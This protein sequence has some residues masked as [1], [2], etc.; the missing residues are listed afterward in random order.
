MKQQ[1]N[2]VRQLIL[3]LT[4]SIVG[5]FSLI[6]VYTLFNNIIKKLDQKTTN[7][8]TKIDLGEYIVED[9]Y[10]IR[11]DFYELATTA[12]NKHSRR[13]IEKRINKKLANIKNTLQVLENGGTLKR[14]IRLNI[15][16]HDD[17]TKV[18]TYNKDKLSSVSLEAIDLH[19]KLI[20]FQAM[21]ADLLILLEQKEQYEKNQHIQEYLIYSKRIKRF[22]KSTPAFF[23]RTIEN[24]R[25]LLYE[26]EIKLR[27]LK[28]EIQYEKD[29]YTTLESI[30]VFCII[31]LMLI[32]GYIIAKQITRDNKKLL[33][34]NKELNSN[35][36]ELQSQKAYV[37]G[38]LD[39]Q[40][41][42]IVVSDGEKM[43][44]ANLA[45]VEFFDGYNSFDD[46][47]TKHACICDYFIDMH[48]PEY[49][50]D[51]DYPEGMWFERVLAHPDQLFKAAMKGKDKIHC[52]TLR[53]SQKAISKNESL[54]IITLNDIT[55][56]LFTNK[57]LK[58]LNDNL[59]VLI[60][61][62]TKKLQDLNDNLEQ[63]IKEEVQK[64]REKDKRMIQQ[65]RYAAMGEMIGNIAH[66]W[67]Q[68]LSAILS[69][70]SSMQ[71]QID[72]G[73]SNNK[74]IRKSFV[75]IVKYVEF[76]NQT[77]EDFRAFFKKDKQASDFNLIGILKN[78]LNIVNA[79]YKD[80]RINVIVQ[81]EH[82]TLISNGFPNELA[83]AYINILNNAKDALIEKEI[84]QKYVF[85]KSYQ[86]EEY[87]IV[88]IMDNSGGID[89]T[90]ISKIF[91]PYFTT[92]HQSQ[93]TGI[94]LYM[95][96]YI[97]EKHMK[98]NLSVNNQEFFVDNTSYYGACFKIALPISKNSL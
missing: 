14:V 98:G 35:I 59:E 8:E 94:G 37:R 61:E 72:L 38:L 10:K 82:E 65:S 60:E 30:L 53:V 62:K 33:F 57:R 93:G 87:N 48:S 26:G 56:E 31:M 3:L 45:L 41:N 75:N 86:E 12:S 55:N 80:N 5:M 92:K 2:T 34:F 17:L 68:P 28:H 44:D 25:R 32:L 11:S 51:I 85:I 13:I 24:T 83:Q 52:F 42:I 81:E 27:K 88:Q 73:I 95:S 20:Q 70:S 23:T 50:I 22:Y 69:T 29:N 19:P 66:Q 89:E 21:M 54:I 16:G 9:L 67:R 39:A 40:P 77:I 47:K 97:I 15:A 64:N 84:K 78:S 7:L 18:L 46:F 79:L 49:I 4:V 6:A 90:I 74:D 1:A 71:L 91:D 36:Q 43:I 63:K 96:K 58:Q 76:L